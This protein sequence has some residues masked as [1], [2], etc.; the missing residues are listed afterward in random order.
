MRNALAYWIS[1]VRFAVALA[2]GEALSTTVNVYLVFGEG[3]VGVPLTVPVAE[4][5]LNGLGNA[6]ETDHSN[7]AT[8]PLVC[9]VCV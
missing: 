7:G 4:L 1:N 9:K 6:G 5:R 3:P 8:P 2:A